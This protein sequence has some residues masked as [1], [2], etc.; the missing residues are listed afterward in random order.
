MS[1]RRLHIECGR[2]AAP[3]HCAAT[4]KE[5]RHPSARSMNTNIPTGSVDTTTL[6]RKDYGATRVRRA[7]RVGRVARGN[8]AYQDIP[9]TREHGRPQRRKAKSPCRTVMPETDGTASAGGKTPPTRASPP[10]LLSAPAVTASAQ[11]PGPL[12]RFP[13]HALDGAV[14]ASPK[15]PADDARCDRGSAPR[16]GGRVAPATAGRRPSATECSVSKERAR[17][18]SSGRLLNPPVPADEVVHHAAPRVRS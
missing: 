17:T 16:W 4:A 12:I 18:F 6:V 7:C 9:N 3:G 14:C 8:P 10:G 1:E 5:S 15:R 13:S 11:P 2:A